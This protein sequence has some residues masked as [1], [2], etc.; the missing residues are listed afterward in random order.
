MAPPNL[1]LIHRGYPWWL[2]PFLRRDVA[3]ITL[4][5]HI[6]VSAAVRGEAMEALLRHERVHVAQQARLGLLWFLLRYL[7]EYGAN[8]LRG[9]GAEE[10]YRRISFEEEAFAAE[11]GETV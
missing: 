8:R 5:R 10:A 7:G 2:R 11:R 9:L 4:G 3:A 1:P 6:W